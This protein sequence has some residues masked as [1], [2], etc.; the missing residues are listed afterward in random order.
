MKKNIIN[1]LFELW[2]H[3][4]VNG[5]FLHS[6]AQYSYVKPG[7][8]SWPNKVFRLKESETDFKELYQHIENGNIPDSISIGEKKTLETQLLA[9]NFKLKSVVKGM[10]LN[11][12]KKNKP[13]NDFVSNEK[14]DNEVKAMEF[15]KIASLSFGYE[16]LSSTII[17]LINSSQLKLF[18][19]KHSGLYVS[20]GMVLLDQKG[21]SGLHMIGTIPEYR[22]LGLGKVMTNK[23]LFESFENKSKQVVLVASESGER[24]YSK[25]GFVAQGSLKSYSI[26]K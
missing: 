12:Q 6:T 17:S 5:Q 23:L 26:N 25:L 3:I 11:L 4:G 8:C 22:G 9:H 24:I 19:G 15:A 16:I 1:N 20:C 2:E 21:I 7:N 18:I 10:Y 13:T 14:V